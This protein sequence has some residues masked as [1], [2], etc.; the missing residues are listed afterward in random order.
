MTPAE[1]AAV[2]RVVP[3]YLMEHPEVIMD[4]L[5][6][7]QSRQ[8]QAARDQQAQQLSGLEEEVFRAP[9]SPVIGNAEGDVTLVEFFDYQCGYCKSMLDP[10]N[11][12]RERDGNL[13]MVMKEFPILSRSEERRGGKE[14]GRTC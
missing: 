10:L 4:A 1:E 12:L 3:D 6:A 9:G 2:E 13:R 14:C 7:L 5:T 8:E 11:G